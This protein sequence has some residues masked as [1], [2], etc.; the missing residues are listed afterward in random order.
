MSDTVCSNPTRMCARRAAQNKV[1]LSQDDRNGVQVSAWIHTRK[2]VARQ[3][4][5]YANVS[6]EIGVPGGPNIRI[7]RS[8][9]S[10]PSSHSRAAVPTP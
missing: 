8:L 2:L 7:R 5:Q 6:A 10:A 4:T 1:I 3:G 9:I